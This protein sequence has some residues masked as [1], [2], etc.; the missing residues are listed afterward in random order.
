M[1]NIDT[2][3]LN[4]SY[5]MGCS[6]A[7]LESYEHFVVSIREPQA[8]KYSMFL[9]CSKRSSV[10]WKGNLRAYSIWITKHKIKHKSNLPGQMTFKFYAAPLQKSEFFAAYWSTTYPSISCQSIIPHN[11]SLNHFL[12]SWLLKPCTIPV[13]ILYHLNILEVNQ[14]KWR[15]QQ[16]E[17][18]HLLQM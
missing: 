8:S 7:K 17:T 15:L 18:A 10:A 16:H 4:W 2:N 3:N 11:L 13:G 14:R 9:L 5:L 1:Y 6:S 12:I